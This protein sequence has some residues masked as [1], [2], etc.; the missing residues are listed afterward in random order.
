MSI[1]LRP[2]SNG[3]RAKP[4]PPKSSPV[5]NSNRPTTRRR[6]TPAGVASRTRSAREMPLASA[7]LRWRAISIPRRA[8]WPATVRES[9]SPAA[10]GCSPA[11]LSLELAA[12]E[13]LPERSTSVKTLVT[14]PSASETSAVRLTRARVE[15]GTESPPTPETIK[16]VRP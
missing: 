5:V 9:E 2:D 7:Q 4:W 3:I 13:A 16:S 12:V 6:L 1:S 15:R 10:A 8:S 14:F 11:T